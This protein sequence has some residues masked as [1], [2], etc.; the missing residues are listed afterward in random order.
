VAST[1]LE[2]SGHEVR[3]AY[4]GQSAVSVARVFQPQ[5]AVLDIGMPRMDGYA[6]ARLL[7]EEPWAASLLLVAA[8]GWGDAQAKAQTASAGFDEHLTKP[9]LPE[10]LERLLAR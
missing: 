2:L 8:T 3:V 4:D 5:V 10:D 1:L 9:V 6:A 7:R